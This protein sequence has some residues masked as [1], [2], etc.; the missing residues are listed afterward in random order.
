MHIIDTNIILRYSLQDNEKLSKQATDLIDNNIV[1]TTTEVIAEVCYVLA[2]VYQMPRAE[3][4]EELLYLFQDDIICHQ[5]KPFIITAIKIYQQTSLDF[6][7][8][9]MIAY[10][11]SL[12]YQ[13]SSFDKKINNH[14]RRLK[15]EIP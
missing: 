3:I 8:C 5:D 2:K 14:I 9:A 11:Q 10:Y 1:Y 7:D 13:V 6:V 12:N 15:G 4:A